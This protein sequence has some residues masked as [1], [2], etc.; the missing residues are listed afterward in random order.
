MSTSIFLLLLAASVFQVSLAKAV[1][2]NWHITWVNAAPD[3]YERPVIGINGQWPCPKIEVDKGDHLVIDVYND[4]GN[5]STGL[6]WHG[7]HMYM[8]G[9]MDGATGTTQCPIPPGQHMR[10]EVDV[11]IRPRCLVYCYLLTV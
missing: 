8:E 4:L 11:C 10:Y 3:G 7:L 1:Y 5:Q 6:H 2:Y 9:Y